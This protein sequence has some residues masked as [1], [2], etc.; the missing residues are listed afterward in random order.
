[1]SSVALWIVFSLRTEENG[2]PWIRP[3]SAIVMGFAIASM[4]YTEMAAVCFH[5]A[6]TLCNDWDAVSI[7]AFGT[8]GIAALTFPVLTVVALLT[9]FVNKK[10][11][12]Q[13]R[14]LQLRDQ[15]NRLLFENNVAAVCRLS[16]DGRVLAAN[17]H[18]LA[19]LGYG[20]ENEIFGMDIRD[21]YYSLEE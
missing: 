20:H 9:G 21:H 11:A 14:N 17:S 15:E 3:A 7:S 1:M 2:S 19:Y 10:F 6:S 13:E 16:F 5:H 4:H 12:L 18:F 8:A